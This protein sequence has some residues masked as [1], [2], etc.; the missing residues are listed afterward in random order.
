MLAVMSARAQSVA[1]AG[2]GRPDL[3]L[4]W[5]QDLLSDA[6]AQ[7]LGRHLAARL[8]TLHIQLYPLRQQEE[9]ELVGRNALDALLTDSVSVVTLRERLGLIRPLAS[10]QRLAPGS[11]DLGSAGLVV[12]SARRQELQRLAQLKHARILLGPGDRSAAWLA[13][14]MALQHAG[15]EPDDVRLQG[16]DG[17]AQVLLRALEQGEADAVFLP[18]GQLESLGEQGRAWRALEPRPLP[19]YPW[20]LGTP[21]LPGPQLVA[22]AHLDESMQRR[23]LAALLTVE[24]ATGA[25]TPPNLGAL[26]LSFSLAQDLGSVQA[27]MKHLRLS[28]FDA[29]PRLD[30]R[31]LARQHP[32]TAA[33]AVAALAALLLALGLLLIRQRAAQAL[34]QAQSRLQ[35]VLSAVPDLM[36][37]V[38]AA[39]TYLEVWASDPSLLAAP[40]EQLLGRRIDE[41]L[42]AD[43]AAVVMRALTATATQGR[44]S[45]QQ[46]SLELPTGR[47]H[48]ELSI[49]RVESSGRF[50]LLSRDVTERVKLAQELHSITEGAGDG[51]WTTDAE[52]RYTYANPAALSI[53]GHA[54]E[55]LLQMSIPE[56][57][58]QDALPR[59]AAS[60]E[61]MRRD[62]Q[63]QRGEWQLRH[64]QGH[65]VPVELTSQRLPD[66]RF[67]A[68][69]RDI[70]A[71]LQ[72]LDAQRRAARVFAAAGE[73]LIVTDTDMVIVDVNPAFTR[74]TGYTR[75]EALGRKPSMLSSG[76]QDAAF[77][78]TL[79]RALHEHGVWRGEL[80][81]RR[82]NGEQYPERLAITA[83]R[84]DAG[85]VVEYL[86][87]FSDISLAKQHELELHRIAYFDAL[88]GLPNRRLLAD[89][90]GQALLRAD[91]EGQLC[92]VCYL[93]LD[94]FKPVN[95][96]LGHGVGDQLL[97]Q[98][99]KQLTHSLRGGDTLARMGGDEFVLVLGDLEHLQDCCLVLQR[100]LEAVS[101]PIQVGGELVRISASVGVTLYPVDAGDGDTL[102][103]HADQAMYK[104]KELGK[105]RYHIFDAEQ[106]RRRELQRDALAEIELAFHRGEFE[107]HYQPKIDLRNG[108][109]VGSEALLRWRRADASMVQPLEF[110]PLLAGHALELR[111]S[112]WVVETA[113]Q[114]IAAWKAAGLPHAISVNMVPAHLEQAEFVPWLA[115]LLAAH[116]S[117]SAG[118]LQLE[119]LESSALDSLERSAATLSTLRHMGISLA[120]D[121]FGTGYSSLAY[122]RRL[123][124]DVLKIDRGFVHDM[125]VDPEDLGIVDNV[126]RLAA[127]FNRHVIAEGVESM[128]HCRVLLAL[129]C[130]YA[131]GYGIA[132]P[133]PAQR[134]AAWLQQWQQ[135]RRWQAG[136]VGQ[137]PMPSRRQVELSVMAAHLR[138]WL[139][140]IGRS[141]S[142]RNAED[143]A[144]SGGGR[145]LANW[146]QG[147]G[148][149]QFG[150]LAQFDQL[151]QAS[152]ALQSLLQ[153]INEHLS[154][155]RHD[156]A[157]ECLHELEQLVQQAL[158]L[159]ESLEQAP[160]SGAALAD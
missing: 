67:L 33:L 113:V 106:D 17:D 75:E 18:A 60:L 100:L 124:M 27:A 69:G 101:Q 137:Q 96:R 85:K 41:V 150:Q 122:F 159:L 123:P 25:G 56:L 90:L 134:F 16:R 31:A 11:G 130:E 62:G 71:E 133:M 53:T 45:G 78:E 110:L 145:S 129:G 22:M 127:A 28:P 38:D 117:L 13:P 82:K 15:L 94:G 116:P 111:V 42:P 3:V 32:R 114:Q 119:V 91:R 39:G 158:N 21:V 65:L 35:S 20:Q 4:G 87:V 8:P 43:A 153:R 160:Q 103:R 104:A 142:S 57:L 59:L 50:I 98:V 68:I 29:E 49:A 89:R 74:I 156:A 58:P 73:G 97:L 24:D 76:R 88:T 107:L 102:L 10:L 155:Q 52:G 86:G 118:D 51:I 5:R 126:V 64:K 14:L 140:R 44:C 54:R 79:D 63:I 132:R 148:R 131:Q 72:A 80:W 108:Q 23:L 2:P 37:E 9:A 135:E 154:D 19:S 146:L 93:D 138:R 47:H 109:V 141:L 112:A 61:R 149:R 66:G 83:V 7:A 105:N 99:A 70:S 77:Y 136:Q 120:L 128:E 26:G 151:L 147:Q 144:G 12:V 92:A 1:E 40:R 84:D 143:L 34:R 95:D 115:A 6:Q 81:N 121:D 48:F 139:E 36:F 55:E 30:L 46:F 152:H 125:L 157:S